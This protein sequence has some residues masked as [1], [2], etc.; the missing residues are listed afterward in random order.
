MCPQV[1]THAHVTNW[2]EVQGEDKL[3]A[4]CNGSGC[5]QKRML[6]HATEEMHYSRDVW[7]NT[8]ELEE[9]QA[10][11][12]VQNSFTMKKGVL[13]VNTMPKGETKGLLAFVV[14]STHQ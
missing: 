13:Y 2:G 14:P 1:G 9:G 3:V 5:T 12:R 7:V 10:M 6:T 8:L 11:F 4:A